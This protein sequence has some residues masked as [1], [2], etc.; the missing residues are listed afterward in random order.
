MRQIVFDHR[1]KKGKIF[2]VKEVVTRYYFGNK[3]SPWNKNVLQSSEEWIDAFIY[4]GY[5]A[6]G[7]DF[8]IA[9][10]GRF[11]V[12]HIDPVLR[13]LFLARDWMGE[14]PFHFLITETGFYFANT[15]QTIKEHTGEH[16]QYEHIRSFPQSHYQV[17]EL[18]H[19]D[20][21]HIAATYRPDKRILYYNF[22]VDVKSKVKK[23]MD[24]DSYDFSRLA[25]FIKQAILR[26]AVKQQQNYLLL[27]G[28]LDSLSVAVAMKS[29][30]VPFE[31]FTISIDG[32]PGEWETAKV[33]AEKLNVAHTI[34]NITS[35]EILAE[36]KKSIAIGEI[37]HLYNI[38]C[39]LGML[40]LGEKLA[41][42]GIK[43]AFCG[44]AMNETVGDYKDWKVFDPIAQQLVTL[45]N[46]NTERLQNIEERILYVWGHSTD[47]G[48][49]NRQLGTGLAKHAGARMIKP[50]MHHGIEL[51]CPYYEKNFLSAIISLT[52]DQLKDAGLKPGILWKIFEED[53]LRYGFEE[54]E[55][56][57][58]KKVRLQDAGI[59]TV[60]LGAG[61][62]Q[63]QTIHLFN[64]IFNTDYRV[65]EKAKSLLCTA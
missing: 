48:K 62:D 56:L 7:S 34:I 51:E 49:Y 22:E 23:G 44:E 1:S 39:T 42:R 16:F 28:G 21:K 24:M 9:L 29:A 54:K 13:V 45:Q 36:Y 11:A 50:F 3:S 52:A 47:K 59:T 25:P 53:F 57:E 63:E 37:Y 58:C 32:K 10:E 26:R 40:L 46:I 31:T 6:Y 55:I 27:S 41:A 4:E 15:V 30:G 20:E 12:V 61:Y 60:L 38:Y 35:A 17:I 14:M 5:C 33:F 2:N 64:N 8:L 65:K 18:V 19:I 43:R